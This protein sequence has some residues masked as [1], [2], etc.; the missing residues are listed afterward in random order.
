VSERGGAAERTM[1]HER[2]G[3]AGQQLEDVNG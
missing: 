2:S 1:Q 3:A